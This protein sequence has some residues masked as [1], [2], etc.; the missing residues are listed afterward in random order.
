MDPGS[1]AVTAMRTRHLKRFTELETEREDIGRTL[2]A[3]GKQ[4][5]QESGGDPSLLDRVPML[6]DILRDAPDRIKQQLFDAFDIQALYNK[7]AD[8]VTLWATITP[9]TPAAPAAIIANSGTPDLA[10]LLTAQ[11]HPSD[12][13]SQPGWATSP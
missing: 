9:S 13:A 2:A 11:D 7:A 6:G 4:T 10:A 3:L 12:L 5:A 1:A 8:Q